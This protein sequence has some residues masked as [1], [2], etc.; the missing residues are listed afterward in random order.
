MAPR[1]TSLPI[2]V[3]EVL[4][5]LGGRTLATASLLEAHELAVARVRTMCRG[6][7]QPLARDVLEL[8]SDLP[9]HRP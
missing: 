8:L 3:D 5:E 4:R 2:P 6:S 9:G 1:T 7:G